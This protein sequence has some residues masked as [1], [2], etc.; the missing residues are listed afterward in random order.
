MKDLVTSVCHVSSGTVWLDCE[1]K[2]T[3]YSGFTLLHRFAFHYQN[4]KEKI[5]F[6]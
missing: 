5:S 6:I 2:E 1:V 3:Y 4:R